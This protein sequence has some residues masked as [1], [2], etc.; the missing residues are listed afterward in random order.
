MTE[1]L[2]KQLTALLLE[3]KTLKNQLSYYNKLTTKYR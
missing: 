3:N 1:E 2:K